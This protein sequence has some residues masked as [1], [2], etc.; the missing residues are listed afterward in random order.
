VFRSMPMTKRKKDKK[1][2][3]V[4]KMARKT[5]GLVARVGDALEAA[6]AAATPPAAPST[7]P[8]LATVSATPPATPPSVAAAP[9]S[10]A[11]TPPPVAA[12][13]PPVAAAPPPVVDD[14]ARAIAAIDAYTTLH[15]LGAIDMPSRPAMVAAIADGLARHGTKF[16]DADIR[17]LIDEQ[18]RIHFRTLG[19]RMGTT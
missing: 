1:A 6:A 3:P 4:A 19:A 8:P 7:S 14:D 5:L 15:N 17:S 13:P 9:P 10:V 12:T 11:A 18:M 16:T 2:N